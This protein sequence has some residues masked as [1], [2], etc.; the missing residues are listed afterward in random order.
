MRSPQLDDFLKESSNIKFI[1]MS[2]DASPSECLGPESQNA[3][4]PYYQVHDFGIEDLF[5]SFVDCWLIYSDFV[6]D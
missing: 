5:Y 1:N 4:S 3:S 2:A 6:F